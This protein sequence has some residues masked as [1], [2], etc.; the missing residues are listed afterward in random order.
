VITHKDLA[1]LTWVAR[2]FNRPGW[3]YELKYD[4]FRVLGAKHGRVRELRSRR[5]NDLIDRFPEI[6]RE[7]DALPDLVFDAEL[8]I[9]DDKGLSV[10]DELAHRARMRSHKAIAY[11]AAEH[12]ATLFVFD[13]LELAGEDLR[14]LPLLERKARLH[15]TLGSAGRIRPLTHIPDQGELLFDAAEQHGAEGIVA[16]KADAP[17]PRGR[18]YTWVKIKTSHGRH[19]DQA[20]RKPPAPLN[21]P[22]GRAARTIR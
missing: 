18:S 12:P 20:R 7:M 17:Y 1:L 5:G 8:V 6:E 21:L 10:F 16:K 15:R 4:G 14:S 13:L 11:A 22:F 19:M 3:L 9:L 2:P